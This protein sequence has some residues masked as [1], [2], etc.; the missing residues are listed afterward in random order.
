M[1]NSKYLLLMKNSEN[2]FMLSNV[3]VC[4]NKR[5]IPVKIIK[6]KGLF[7]LWGCKENYHTCKNQKVNRC[8]NAS[9]IAS[10]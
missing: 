3:A 1:Q 5:D 6:K 7:N 8:Y 2:Y 10:N 4:L 9:M